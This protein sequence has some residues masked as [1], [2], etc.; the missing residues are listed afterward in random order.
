[1]SEFKHILITQFNLLKFPLG[2]EIDKGK[3]WLKWMDKR[4]PIFKNYCLKS[5]LNQSN[6]NF[7]WLIYFDVHTPDKY[8]K[9]LDDLSLIPFIKIRKSDGYDGFMKDYLNDLKFFSQDANWIIS[10]RIDNDDCFHKDAI[11]IIQNHF[12]PKDEHLISLASGNTLNLNSM[13]MGHYIYPGSPFI[14][15]IEP[16]NKANLKSVF[17][18][19][20]AHWNSLK[21]MIFKKTDATILIEHPYWMQL[22]HG[23]NVTNSSNRGFPVLKRKYLSDYGL[24][25][26]SNS[27]SLINVF[28][29]INYVHW[30]RYLKAFI[31]R[32][33]R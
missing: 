31:I 6:K 14:S 11:Q 18:I 16:C 27:Q 23:D 9:L 26:Y 13:E 22:V 3:D 24:D 21:L 32:I 17:Y 33:F 29:Y 4:I 20:H 1:M 15:L 19:S 10:S 12:I 7:V 28:K 30:K 2:D 8:L 25:K 5:L